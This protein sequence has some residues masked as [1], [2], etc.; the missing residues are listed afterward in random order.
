MRIFFEKLIAT[1]FGVGFSPIA[2]GTASSA[3]TA[4]IIWFF[5][6]TQS[7]YYIVAIIILI[8]ISA[9]FC[10]V[11]KKFWGKTDDGKIVLDEFIGMAIA[12]I[13][14]PKNI[15]IF[16]IGFFL[17]RFFDIFKIF[18]AGRAE[19]IKGGWGVLLDDVIVGIYTNIILLCIKF[20]FK[21]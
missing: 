2:P 15:Y 10:G 8:P 20:F 11:G 9:Y 14:I 6:P 21:I 17:F 7:I 4:I 13:W 18:P 1:F 16:V 19:K 5:I 3:I 12:F